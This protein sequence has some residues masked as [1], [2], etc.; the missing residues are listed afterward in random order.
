M[1]PSVSDAKHTE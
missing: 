1:H